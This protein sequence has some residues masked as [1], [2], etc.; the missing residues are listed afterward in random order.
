MTGCPSSVP[1][2]FPGAN[3]PRPRESLAPD[4]CPGDDLP[5]GHAVRQRHCVLDSLDDDDDVAIRAGARA[6]GV[7]GGQPALGLARARDSQA[8]DEP[9]IYRRGAAPESPY[10]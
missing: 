7:R 3:G 2:S 9:R 5:A 1:G 8:G 10:A 6:G 4:V